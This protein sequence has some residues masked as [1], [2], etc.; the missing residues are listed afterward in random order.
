[1]KKKGLDKGR[2][3]KRVKGGQGRGTAKG[4]QT[5]RSGE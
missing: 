2:E 3:L 4:K 1:M 5:W